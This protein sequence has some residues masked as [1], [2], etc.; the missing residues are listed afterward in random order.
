M[1]YIIIFLIL[2][3]GLNA[4]VYNSADTTWTLQYQEVLTIRKKI[5]TAKQERRLLEAEI[6]VLTKMNNTKDLIIKKQQV[7]D[8]LYQM[9]LDKYKEM[10]DIMRE[11]VFLSNDI[12]NNYKILLLSTEENLRATEKKRKSAEFWKQAYK[13]GLPAA[14]ILT[15]LLIK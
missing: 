1:K 8:S 9:E 13:Y 3:G 15:I 2:A 11:K 14:G 6:E 10:D 7:R 12:I 5:E 4:Q